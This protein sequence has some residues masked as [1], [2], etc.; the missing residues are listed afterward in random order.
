[1]T[2][3]FLASCPE[4]QMRGICASGQANI[5]QPNTT[6]LPSGNNFSNPLNIARFAAL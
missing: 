6:K 3:K 2:Q 5:A 4:A 1:M